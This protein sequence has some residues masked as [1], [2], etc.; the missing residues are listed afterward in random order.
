MRK[1]YLRKYPVL[2]M[3]AFTGA[4][5]ARKVGGTRVVTT[6]NVWAP[7]AD[8]RN[9]PPTQASFYAL[10]LLFMGIAVFCSL[11]IILLSI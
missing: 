5:P 11:L 3:P 6:R 10:F 2:A 4:N 9:V 7:A 1:L 8:S